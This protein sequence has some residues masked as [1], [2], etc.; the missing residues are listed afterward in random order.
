MSLAEASFCKIVCIFV[1][2]CNEPLI[3]IYDSTCYDQN[4]MSPI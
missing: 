4:Q 3:C 1:G 2:A